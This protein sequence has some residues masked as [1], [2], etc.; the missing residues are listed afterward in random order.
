MMLVIPDS[1][2]EHVVLL[3]VQTV[4]LLA[5]VHENIETSLFVTYAVLLTLLE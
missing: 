2:C 3:T 1:A 5:I 4:Q